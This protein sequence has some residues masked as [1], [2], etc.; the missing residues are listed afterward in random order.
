MSDQEWA[1][2]MARAYA[3][4]R[5]DMRVLRRGVLWTLLISAA[6]WGL[7]WKGGVWL[8]S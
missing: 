7:L 5:E 2:Y 8:F 4:H 1:V 6:M 3:R